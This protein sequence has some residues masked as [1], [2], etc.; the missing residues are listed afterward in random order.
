MKDTRTSDR[1]D[2]CS[3]S[4]RNLGQHG[5]ETQATDDI[6]INQILIVIKHP[7]VFTLAQL[8]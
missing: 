3:S 2:C 8:S 1:E 6:F 5:D 7:G 4:R